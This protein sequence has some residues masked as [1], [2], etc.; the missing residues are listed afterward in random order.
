MSET[1]KSSTALK[2][3]LPILILVIGVVAFKMLGNLKKAPQRQKPPQLGILVDVMDLQAKAH[4]VSVHATGTVAAEQEIALVPEVS[5]K[6]VW[7]SPQLVSG[8][9]FKRGE[10]LLKVEASDYQLAVEKARADIARAEVALRTEQ[11]KAR[12]AMQEWQRIELPDKGVPGPLVTH[13]IQLQQ[14]QANLAAVRANL[15][16]AELNLQRTALLAPFDGRIRQEQVDLGQYLRAGT[17]IGN[18][19]GTDR[20][21]I[22]VPLP[23]DE[24]RWLSIPTANNKATGSLAIISLPG[25]PQHQWQG[26]IVR[27]LGEI[28]ATSRMAKIV[29]GVDDPY[30]LR[31]TGKGPVLLN[32]QFVEIQIFGQ[33][34][35]QIISI[36]RAALRTGQQVWIADQENRLRLRPVK[37]LRREQQQLVLEGGVES[38]E[39]LILTTLSGAADGLLLRPVLQEP[40][41]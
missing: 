18:F 13:E 23:I 33:H 1:K 28:D 4:Q 10:T 41:Q 39:K 22:H 26:K 3:I 27:S 14:E 17:S 25:N 15:K 30:Q 5:G 20:A 36:P 24:L 21:E 37:I 29:I 9:L 40:T 35:G 16:Q 34:L 8:G 12:V 11:E 2:I 19:S 32:G 6:V 38:G 31:G 7:L